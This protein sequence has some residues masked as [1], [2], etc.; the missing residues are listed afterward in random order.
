[1]A[2]KTGLM[3]VFRVLMPRK[4]YPILLTSEWVWALPKRFFK[5]NPSLGK[6]CG[7]NL[8]DFCHNQPDFLN[9]TRWPANLQA[10]EAVKGRGE[11]VAEADVCVA[12]GLCQ[13]GRKMGGNAA[14]K[15]HGQVAAAVK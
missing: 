7:N 4:I 2:V 3:A 1:M 9:K 11:D 14:H 10:I 8:R 6:D 13:L 15:S 5:K 12:G